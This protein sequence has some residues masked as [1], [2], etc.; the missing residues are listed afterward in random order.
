MQV[1]FNACSYDVILKGC[2]QVLFQE[3]VQLPIEQLECV[4]AFVGAHG[5]IKGQVQVLPR[6]NQR[7]LCFCGAARICSSIFA[8]RT[9]VQ[10]SRSG[11]HGYL[12]WGSGM[13]GHRI[14]DRSHRNC[15]GTGCDGDSE[16]DRTP[17]REFLAD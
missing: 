5:E 9:E 15:G 7:R 8:Q 10:R 1:K 11:E 13:V 14:D 2:G 6:Q 12:S 16:S 4:W 3:R 17:L